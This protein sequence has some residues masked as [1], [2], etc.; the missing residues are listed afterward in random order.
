VLAFHRGLMR[1]RS[2]MGGSSEARC[3]SQYRRF[4]GN[5]LESK[6]VADRSQVHTPVSVSNGAQ[7][8]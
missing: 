6:C 3:S 8:L 5:A 1:S 2:P 7:H 4:L